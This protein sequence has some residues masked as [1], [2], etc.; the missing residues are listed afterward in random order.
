MSE[1]ETRAL[2]WFR[3][4]LRDY[5]HAALYHALKSA[6]RIYCVFVFDT[7]ILDRLTD[8][9]DRRVE[10]IH[11]SVAELKTALQSV[12]SDLIVLHGAARAEIPRL[13]QALAVD[14]VYSNRDYEPAAV[15]RDTEVATTLAATGIDFLQFKNQVIFEQD[16]I[17]T[18]ASRP[19]VVFTPYKNAW[20]RK[21][22]DFFL[23]PYP[24]DRYR[25]ALAQV[26]GKP[27][28]TLEALG[29]CRTN[30]R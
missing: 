27:M 18:N 2:V 8:K 29:F 6:D 7:D 26:E 21:V 16:E 13:A 1:R 12:G 3:R 30:L 17:L 25:N 11:D 22:D 5:D 20:R 19:F 14:A 9:A 10:F 23:K 28:P 15:A 24:V 4:D